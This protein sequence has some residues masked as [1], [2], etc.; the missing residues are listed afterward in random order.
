MVSL[1]FDSYARQIARDNTS[2]SITMNIP[3]HRSYGDFDGNIA[4][5]EFLVGE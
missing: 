4:R 3:G 5:W 1:S 2:H